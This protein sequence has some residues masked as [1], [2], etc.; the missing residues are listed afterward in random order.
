MR[1]S[2]SMA[3]LSDLNC[4]GPVSVYRRCSIAEPLA[5][6]LPSGETLNGDLV[7]RSRLCVAPATRCYL[8]DHGT[9]RC[10]WQERSL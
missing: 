7:Q 4:E 3:I 1:L 9:D 2:R 6:S 5:V 8:V 10:V